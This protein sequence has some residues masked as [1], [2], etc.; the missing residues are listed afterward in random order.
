M[1]DYYCHQC[2]CRR[3]YLA[4]IDAGNLMGTNYQLEKYM[5]HTCPA[6]SEAIQSVFAELLARRRMVDMS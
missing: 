2:A 1:S 6:S 3:G 4:R 5:K